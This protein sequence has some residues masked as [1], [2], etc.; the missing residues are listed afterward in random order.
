MWAN[1]LKR[2]AGGVAFLVALF[3]WGCRAPETPTLLRVD[4]VQLS[5]FPNI[6]VRATLNNQNTRN[7]KLTSAQCNLWLDDLPLAEL[8]LEEPVR[9]IKKSEST[10]D[11]KLSTRFYSTSDELR[12]LLA[13]ATW[14]VPN[15]LDIELTISGSYGGLRFR[16]KIARMHYK[17]F[18]R[19]W[20]IPDLSSILP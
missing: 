6:W 17:D 2:I 14:G 18:A 11:I 13:A 9:L 7:I 8:K 1:V 15:N 20:G 4:E 19:E 16:R 3:L 12:F 5:E 10:V